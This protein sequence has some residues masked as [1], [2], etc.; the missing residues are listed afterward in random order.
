[1]NEMFEVRTET[2]DEPAH[3]A[4][5]VPITHD[6]V[7]SFADRADMAA[8]LLKALGHEGRLLILCY[9]CEGEK[10]VTELENLL[11]QRQA[12]V[13]QQLSRLRYEGLVRPRRDG[14]TMFYSLADARLKP[15]LELVYRT[16]SPQLHAV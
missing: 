9:L 10:S 11:D 16:F 8:G 14:K 12:A 13:S 4:S 6:G 15:I 1:M 5:L 2:A 7:K 3:G